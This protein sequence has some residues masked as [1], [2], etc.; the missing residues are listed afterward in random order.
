M[1]VLSWR[2]AALANTW[3]NAGKN[4][5]HTWGVKVINRFS[6]TEGF[7]GAVQC[8]SCGLFHFDHFVVPEVLSLDTLAP[9]REGVGLLHLTSLFP[10]VSHWPLTSHA[11]GHAALTTPRNSRMPKSLLPVGYANTRVQ[12]DLPQFFPSVVLSL[13]SQHRSVSVLVTI[14]ELQPSQWCVAI[15]IRPPV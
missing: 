5:E 7:G 13:N 8:E 6:L 14:T 12:T 9:V 15:G 4:L 11:S 1:A 10:F 3:G 2:Y